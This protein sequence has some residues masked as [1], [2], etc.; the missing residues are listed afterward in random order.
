[1]T[2]SNS[3]SGGTTVY[4]TGTGDIRLGDSALGTGTVTIAGAG[5]NYLRAAGSLNFANDFVINAGST[6]RLGTTNS[7]SFKSTWSGAISGAGGIYYALSDAG[8]YLTGTNS[9]FG[10]GVNNG[11]SGAVYVTSLGMAG[12]N[13][14]IGTNGTITLSSDSGSSGAGTIQWLGTSSEISDK[15][16]ALSAISSSTSQGVK[17]YAGDSAQGGTNVTLTLNG[18]IN[19]TTTNNKVV[20]LG[21]YNGNTL[22]LNGSI[23]QTVG[24]T[25]SVA[26][27]G[28]SNNGT[29]ILANSN[30]SFGGAVSINAGA[31]TTNT[32]QVAQI[33]NAGANS[34][35][36]TNGTINIGGSSSTGLNALKYTGSGETSDKVINLAGTFGGAT[37]DQSGTGNLKFTSAMTA[38]GA[39]AK[40]LIL[41]GSTA[42]TGEIASNIGD[43]GGNVI[44]LTKS[45]SGLWT[46]SGSISYTGITTI[47]AGTLRLGGVNALPASGVLLGSS[48]TLNASTL[49]LAVGG[50]YVL[51]SLGNSTSAGGY[52]SFTNS[53]GSAATLTFTGATNSVTLSSS[54]SGGRQV[55]NNS[56]DLTVSFNGAVD[57]GSST[58]GAVTFG[59]AGNTFLNGAI[60]NTNTALRGLTKT[61]SGTVTLAGANTYNGDTTVSAGSLIVASTGS[62]SSSAVSISN[63]AAFRFNGSSPLSASITVGGGG[64]GRAVLG[65]SGTINSSVALDSL[66]DVLSPGN[67]PGTLS[68]SQNQSWNSFTYDWEINNFPGT[69]AGTDFDNSAI[70]GTLDLTGSSYGL[71][72]LS[73]TAGNVPGNVPNFSETTTSWTILSAS[74][75]ITGFNAGNWAID[76]SG[77]TTGTS[78]LGSFSLSQSGLNDILLTYTVPEPSSFALLG[79]AALGWG[80][81]FVRRRRKS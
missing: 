52:M 80:A 28:I 11:S 15:T 42:G 67:S 65:G 32:L 44:S 7:G 66:T 50:A 37:L 25:T 81:W 3:Y 51:G 36:G 6:L 13:S 49:D 17:I 63:G 56:T 62:I 41:Q 5:T 53:S 2:A 45:G 79:A 73:L 68:L 54:T 26:I 19:S 30:N 39:G 75:G 77:F 29:V 40:T 78:Y 18:N 64:A 72:V 27:N 20:T 59:G 10:G 43:L 34:A 21:A 48:S 71:N 33:G 31:G 46:L 9:S 35:L 76:A 47:G 14:S 69:V 70:T 60:F 12:A 8:L 4:A 1:M 22:V 61:G 23:N 58:A 38:T 74:G 55:V 57:I 16:F 24:Y